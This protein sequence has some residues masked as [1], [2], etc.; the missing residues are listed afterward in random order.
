MCIYYPILLDNLQ[1][2]VYSIEDTY[3]ELRFIEKVNE[4]LMIENNT[5]EI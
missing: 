4:S 5:N 3:H 2:S 1:V